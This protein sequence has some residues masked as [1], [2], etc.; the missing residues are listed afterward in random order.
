MWDN[1]LKG[2][3]MN[4][5]YVEF[6]YFYEL[7]ENWREGFDDFVYVVDYCEELWLIILWGIYCFKLEKDF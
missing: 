6:I 5:V 7:Y 2:V 4:G 1:I 3:K